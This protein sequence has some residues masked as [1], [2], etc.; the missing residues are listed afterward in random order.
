[1]RPVDAETALPVGPDRP[2][3]LL[4]KEDDTPPRSGA[5]QLEQAGIEVST[6]GSMH[7]AIGAV[8]C[9]GGTLDAILCNLHLAGG[10]GVR[11]YHFLESEYPG[12]EQRMVFLRGAVL[13][14]KENEF[15]R[16]IDQ[17]VLELPCW[18]EGLT[19]ILR[20]WTSRRR[21][22]LARRTIV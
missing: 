9:S 16:T 5:S 12:M 1:V 4:V 20:A 21:G 10:G 15:L 13:S 3:I 8:T 17:P 7:D 22:R 2:R 19:V 6:V 14:P 11:L 18:L